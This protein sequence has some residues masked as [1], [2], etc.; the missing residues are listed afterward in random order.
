MRHFNLL[1][2]PQLSKAGMQRIFISIL[3]GFLGATGFPADVKELAEPAIKATVNIYNMML[4]QML[5]TPSKSHYTFNLRD[6]SRVCQGILQITPKFCPDADAFLKLWAHE[7][8]RVFHD[9]LI[10]HTDKSI[11]RGWIVDELKADNLGNREWDESMLTTL[12]FGGYM[13]TTLGVSG[14]VY[15]SLEVTQSSDKFAEYLGDFNMSSTKPMNLVFF[16]DACLHL[17]R[18]SRIVAQPRGCALLVGVGGSGRSSLVRMAASMWDMK[19]MS[20][21]I[22]RTYDN[23][24]WRDDLKS[25][26][27]EAGCTNKPTIFLFSDT[28]IIKESM[29]EV[30]RQSLSPYLSLAPF[31]SSS[32]FMQ[33]CSFRASLSLSLAHAVFVLVHT[34]TTRT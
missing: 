27:F 31:H 33:L 22:T 6:V 29:L 9:R 30:R 20:I 32:H 21:E 13:N 26:M 10:N 11:F 3:G 18:L 23:N 7:T 4:E 17:A 28:Q 24:S 14:S 15:E 1:W 5:P 34:T 25:F 2:I 16:T 12:I 8:C 19:C